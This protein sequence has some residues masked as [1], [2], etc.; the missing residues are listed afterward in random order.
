MQRPPLPETRLNGYYPYQ[1]V[2][3]FGGEWIPFNQNVTGHVA[4]LRLFQTLQKKHGLPG[5]VEDAAACQG[6]SLLYVENG[7]SMKGLST[8][9]PDEQS[10]NPRLLAKAVNYQAKYSGTQGSRKAMTEPSGINCTAIQLDPRPL[11]MKLDKILQRIEDAAKQL[12]GGV[13]YLT[14]YCEGMVNRRHYEAAHAFIIAFDGNRWKFF[15]AQRGEVSFKTFE[16][17]RKWID[18]ESRYGT[19]REL[20][21]RIPIQVRGDGLTRKYTDYT[22]DIY[23]PNLAP[24]KEQNLDAFINIVDSFLKQKKITSDHPHFFIAIQNFANFLH[25]KDKRFV[26]FTA[27]TYL[28]AKGYQLPAPQHRAKL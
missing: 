5:P 1:F 27:E 23:S 4:T 24:E 15:E 3:E 7:C 21:E 11:E 2:Q 18:K 25:S 16:D 6:I 14:G 13:F 17:F 26:E 28:K 8:G 9:T 22:L 10:V 19:L 20:R 12:N